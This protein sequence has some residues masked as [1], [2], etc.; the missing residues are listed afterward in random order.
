VSL[1][2]FDLVPAPAP[3]PPLPATCLALQGGVLLGGNGC[4]IGSS[5]MWLEAE[6]VRL[7][8]LGRGLVV[9]LCLCLYSFFCYRLLWRRICLR[10]RVDVSC[11]GTTELLVT[12]SSGRIYICWHLMLARS[13]LD[14]GVGIVI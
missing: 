5:I 3:P 7:F 10:L 11:D 4:F 8:G 1:D 6:D 13:R 2:A 14:H 12:C 9:R